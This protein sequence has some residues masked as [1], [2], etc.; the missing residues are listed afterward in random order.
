MNICWVDGKKFA[1]IS[2]SPQLTVF[3]VIFLFIE[4]FLLFNTNEGGLRTSSIALSSAI[5]LFLYKFLQ[6]TMDYG[7]KLDYVSENCN[8]SSLFLHW[9]FDVEIINEKNL[10]LS[11][12]FPFKIV[13][14]ISWWEYFKTRWEC[15]NDENFL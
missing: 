13:L 7:E 5:F 1:N 15:E 4:F 12:F 2:W 14:I 8:T 10:K 11:M 9:R 3:D 6:F